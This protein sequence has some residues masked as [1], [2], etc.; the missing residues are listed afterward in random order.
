MTQHGA[1]N[2]QDPYGNSF[3]S[4]N[5]TS[6]TKFPGVVL[7]KKLLQIIYIF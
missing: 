5:L 3:N 2:S 6:P 4:S 7:W 1:H